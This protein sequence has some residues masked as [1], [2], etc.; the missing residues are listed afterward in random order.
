M[1]GLTLPPGFSLNLAELAGETAWDSQPLGAGSFPSKVILNGR[2]TLAFLRHLPTDKHVMLGIAGDA[3]FGVSAK[4]CAIALIALSIGIFGLPPDA[5]WEA[6]ALID[7]DPATDALAAVIETRLGIDP[8]CLF[9]GDPQIRQALLDAYNAIAAESQPRPKGKGQRPLS[10]LLLIQEDEQSMTRVNQAETDTAVK[11]VNLGR[12]PITALTYRT[13]TQDENGILDLPVPVPIGSPQQIRATTGIL[14]ALSSLGS[15][16]LFAPVEGPILDLPASE[17]KIKTY[18]ETIV[19]MASGKNDGLDPDP[20]FFSDTRYANLVQGW[21]DER[22]DLNIYATFGGIVF[23]LTASV[24]GGT[25]GYMARAALAAALAELEAIEAGAVQAF[26][27]SASEGAMGVAVRACMELAKDSTLVGERVRAVLIDVVLKAQQAGQSAATSAQLVALRGLAALVVETLAVAGTLL[28]LADIGFSY[29]DVMTSSKA[30][31]WN[32]IVLKPKVVIDP[33]TGT[34]HRGGNKVLTASVT[35]DLPGATYKYRW[36]LS[37]PPNGV[38]SEVG[39]T[40][41][42]RIIETVSAQVKLVS[43]TGDVEGWV[44]DISVEAF[45]VMPGGALESRGTAFSHITVDASTITEPGTFAVEVF[46][47][48]PGSPNFIVAAV[49]KF[50]K[51][52]GA[53]SYQIEGTG[54][55]SENHPD[56]TYHRTNFGINSFNAALAGIPDNE[57]WQSLNSLISTPAN[58]NTFSGY[59]H[60]EWDPWTFEVT[61]F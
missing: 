14:G 41:V 21:K 40:N 19:L 29:K 43:S 39:A 27:S 9:D 2:P 15:S 20:A 3:S 61:V 55:I 53:I 25:V 35:A 32:E 8:Y 16:A 45:E 34:V 42:G 17:G 52:P 26:L 56:G 60:D 18:Y 1:V 5:A 24:L 33:A 38:L 31:R 30:E 7:A 57:I 51:V 47:D 23:E 12:R 48:A 36:T 44:Y 6:I 50:T 58:V 22:R 54:P 13:K 37:G 59:F 4:G 49:V 28:T 10:N 46:H 11:V